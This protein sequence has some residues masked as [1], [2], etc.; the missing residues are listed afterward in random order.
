MLK[1]WVPER[2]TAAALSGVDQQLRECLQR[3][4]ILLPRDRA[5]AE[6]LET[7][8]RRLTGRALEDFLDDLKHFPP[9]PRDEPR[10]ERR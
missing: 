3:L 6:E 9:V 5:N 4:W 7:H 1:P 10:A 2:Q 8:F